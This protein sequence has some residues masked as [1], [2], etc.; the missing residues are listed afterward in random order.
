VVQRAGRGQRRAGGEHVLAQL[1]LD[2]GLLGPAPEPVGVQAGLDRG[3]VDDRLLVDEVA[4]HVADRSRRSR[5]SA[6]SGACTRAA[7]TARAAPTVATIRGR[8][9]AS[10]GMP[11]RSEIEAIDRACMSV[12]KPLAANPRRARR[13]PPCA[14]FTSSNRRTATRASAGRARGPREGACGSVKLSMWIV[15]PILSLPDRCVLQSVA[16]LVPRSALRTPAD[17]A[18]R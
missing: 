12:V 1:P 4:R 5:A 15:G 14:G 13:G 3:G 16:L 6:R 17:L 11:Y 9:V 7:T 10:M 8:S 18:S 2:L